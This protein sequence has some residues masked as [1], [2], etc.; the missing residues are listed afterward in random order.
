MAVTGVGGVRGCF[1]GTTES[2]SGMLSYV[3][4]CSASMGWLVFRSR[5]G[6]AIDGGSGSPFMNA[7]LNCL[8]RKDKFI[9]TLFLKTKF[10]IPDEI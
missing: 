9:H 10:S 5:V 7:E 6:V 8:K 3:D 2:V 1:G 4:R